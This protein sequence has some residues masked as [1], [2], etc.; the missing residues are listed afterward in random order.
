[1]NIANWIPDLFIKRVLEDGEWT[2]FSPDE[3]PDLHHLYGRKFEERYRQYEEMADRGELR[4][5]KRL[6]AKD[7]WKR[8]LTRL[9]ETGHPWIT[10]KDPANI[11]SPQDH[12]GVIHSSNLCTEITLNTSKDETAVC[13]LGSLNLVRHIVNGRLDQQLVKDTVLVAM[14][15]LDN[16]IDVNFYPVPEARQANL[17]HRPVG[18]GIMGFQDALF[19]LDIR[20]DSEEMVQFSDES[21][22]LIAYYA[23]LA[24]AELAGER[25]SYESYQGSKWQRGIL[26]Q[27]TLDLLEAERGMKIE[28]P[29]GGK[30]DWLPVREAISNYG[31]RNSNCLAIAPT[32]TIAN[33]AGCFP[34]IEP[35]YKSLYVKSNMSGEFTVDNQYLINDLKVLGLWNET[36]LE[37]IKTND[38]SIRQIVAIPQ[39]LRDKYK[40]AFEVDPVWLIRAAAQRGKWIDQ[41]QSLNIFTDTTSGK[42]LS[43]IYIYA[44]KMGLKTTYY[45]RTLGAVGIEKSTVSSLREQQPEQIPAV[46]FIQTDSSKVRPVMANAS[47]GAVVGLCAIDDPD[48]EACQ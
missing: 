27:D 40:E 1:M 21:M 24:S 28:T 37:R 11:R 30:L 43:D 6:R 17:R 2:L 33:I 16:V 41:S 9:F 20:F 19:M 7:L 13:N 3:I 29:R 31:M 47:V 22:E 36:V 34:G 42:V 18:L 10:F 14:R 4:L 44:W 23:I 38:G 25:G 35:I 46:E 15:M 8:M 5:Y 12:C 48:C 45:L 39:R 32:A 26:P